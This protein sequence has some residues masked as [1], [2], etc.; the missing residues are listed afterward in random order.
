MARVEN[1]VQVE[2]EL[3]HVLEHEVKKK[4]V[5]ITL[6]WGFLPNQMANNET[7]TTSYMT[8]FDK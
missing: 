7:L 8:T 4:G 3:I 6:P 2:D 5:K 1:V